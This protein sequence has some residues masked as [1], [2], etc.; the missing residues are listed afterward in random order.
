MGTTKDKDAA[1][2]RAEIAERIEEAWDVLKRM[3]DKERA[4]LR[5]AEAGQVWP[6]IIHSAEE[7]GAWEKVPFRR[8]P[9]TTRQVTRMEE[10]MLN[11]FPAISQ[12]ERKFVR[13]VWLFCALRKKPAEVG[14]ILGCH[15][16]TA[17]VWRDNGL[18]RI[19]AHIAIKNPDQIAMKDR[20]MQGMHHPKRA[21]G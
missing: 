5:Q 1:A 3:P 17:T 12:Q 15:R 4:M 19:A 6:L 20:L 10:V 9:P 21:F 18:D 13:A 7:H 8:P 2:R 11:W 16:E 14:R